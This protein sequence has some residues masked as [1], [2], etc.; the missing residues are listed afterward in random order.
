MRLPPMLAE[1]FSGSMLSV[2]PSKPFT[3]RV[4]NKSLDTTDT[5]RLQLNYVWLLGGS[6]FLVD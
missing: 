4:T 5:C 6:L 3:T 2:I 1:S